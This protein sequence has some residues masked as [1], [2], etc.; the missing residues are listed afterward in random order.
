[1]NKP[2]L[3]LYFRHGLKRAGSRVALVRALEPRAVQTSQH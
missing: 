3:D 2:A 1:M